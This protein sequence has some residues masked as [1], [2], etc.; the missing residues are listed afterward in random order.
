MYDSTVSAAFVL[1]LSV[2]CLFTSLYAVV[3]VEKLTC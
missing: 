2:A 1:V 3:F